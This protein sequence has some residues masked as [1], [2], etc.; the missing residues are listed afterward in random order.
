MFEE[1]R[2]RSE[3]VNNQ[4]AYYG[5]KRNAGNTFGLDVHKQDHKEAEDLKHTR[6]GQG[7]RT[8]VAADENEDQCH[9]NAEEDLLDIW[10]E[11]PNLS[12]L[13]CIASYE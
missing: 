6:D 10:R 2:N 9:K 1:D 8:V 7:E 12:D 5:M 11:V 13:A 3:D 4:I